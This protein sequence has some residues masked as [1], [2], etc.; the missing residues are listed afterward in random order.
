M[1][2]LEEVERGAARLA[3]VGRHAPERR[4]Q[5]RHGPLLAERRHTDGVERR[6]GLG[7]PDLGQNIPFE[8]GLVDHG[9]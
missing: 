4:H 9:S 1:A 8:F 3:L 6:L 2:V 7:R 5:G